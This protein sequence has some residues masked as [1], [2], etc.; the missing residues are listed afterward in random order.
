MKLI[1][2]I[3]CLLSERFLLHRASATC[4]YWFPQYFAQISK[5]LPNQYPWMT[6]MAIIVPLLLI[7]WSL[8]L[9]LANIV[10]GFLTFLFHLVIFYNCLG[11]E[12]P[13]YPANVRQ[14]GNDV[15]SAVGSYFV[16]VNEGMFALI[17]W[18]IL[19]GPIGVLLYKLC[20]LCIKEETVADMAAYLFQL[21][22]WLPARLTTLF[23]LV[24]GNFQQ[25]FPRFMQMFWSS[26]QKND[27]LLYEVG[28]LAART[29][30]DEVIQLIFAEHL[31]EQALIV[32]LVFIALF[33]L[34]ASI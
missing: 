7:T 13:F 11:P 32:Y 6:L 30:N 17:F 26:P 4:F 19:T 5:W 31:V 21:L 8:S 10:F 24:V 34:V 16:K 14:S 18:Y 1:V 33:T 9:L 23:Y 2:I 27:E 20:N 3:L 22:N 28:L 25:G 15:H 12:N 29:K